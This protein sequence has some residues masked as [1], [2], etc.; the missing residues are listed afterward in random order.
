MRLG[1]RCRALLV[2]LTLSTPLRSPQFAVANKLSDDSIVNRMKL[3]QAL[4]EEYLAAKQAWEL[5]RDDMIENT[6]GEDLDAL[7]RRLFHIT[8]IHDS[9]LASKYADVVVRGYSH[10]IRQYTGDM[11]IKTLAET[12]QDAKG[13]LRES[14]MSY[15]DDSMKVCPVQMVPVDWF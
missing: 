2:L 7:T 3:S 5:D 10:V 8:A 11:D 4:L 12:L 15:I 9:Q 6:K 13:A 1:L 14:A